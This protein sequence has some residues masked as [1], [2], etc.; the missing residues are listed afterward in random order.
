[1]TETRGDGRGFR[2]TADDATLREALESANIPTLLLVLAHLTGDRSWLAEPY[3]PSRSIATDDNDTA[4]FTEELQAHVRAEAFAFLRAWRDGEVELA[5]P[6]PVD[7]VADRVGISCGETVPPEY[8]VSMAEEAGFVDRDAHWTAAPPRRREDLRVVVIGAGEGGICTAVK[9]GELGIP[10]TVVERHDAVGGIW[11]EN[12]YPGAGVDTASAL[13]SYSWAQKPDWS[14]Y[15]AKQPEILGYLQEVARDHG[16]LPHVRFGTEVVAAR[17]DDTERVW[18]VGIRPADDPDA[19]PTELVADVLISAVGQLNRPA[20]PPIPGLDSFA[21]PMFHSARW[22]HSVDLTDKRVGIVGTGA[23]A[24]QIVPAVVGGPAHLTVFQRSAQWAIP[25]TNYHRV[26]TPQ[27]RVLME[28]VPWYAAWYRLR[29]MWIYQDKLH[30]TLRRDPDWEHPERSVNAINDRHRRFFAEHLMSEIAGHEDRLLDKVMPTY[31]PYGKRMLIDNGWFAALR[32]D[33]VDLVT[34]AIA[35]VDEKGVE[36][37]DGSR[38]DLDVLVMATGFQSRRMLSPMD[39]RGRSGRSLREIWGDDDA[40]AH[41][42]ITVP[43]FPNLFMVYG[44][45][46]NLGHGGSVIFHTECQVGYISRMLVTMLERDIG[47]VEVRPEVCDEYNR[48]VDEA[49]AELVWTHPGMTNWYRNAE[50]RIVTNSPWRLVDYW[51]MT[52]EPDLSEFVT[53][54]LPEHAA[55]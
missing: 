26:L 37:A 52:R 48:R 45:N 11:L 31:P 22:D 40:R 13:Y 4:G 53:T 35:Q 6:P 17:W 3:L 28:Q 2:M 18:R 49:H 54:P 9:L 36:L 38:V 51:A 41:L 20:Y 47:T 21:G 39:I 8:N 32:R 23:S 5:G 24:M 42:G 1:M 50:G 15:F 27:T 25:N 12:S 43:D 10:Y 55:T 7:D 16:V 14:R 33:D 19:T 30:P 46:T 34:D 44:P 29:L